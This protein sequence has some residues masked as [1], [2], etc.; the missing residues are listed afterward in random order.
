MKLLMISHT[1]AYKQNIVETNTR[2][3]KTWFPYTFTYDLET[4]TKPTI[5]FFR[6]QTDQIKFL[7]LE[8]EN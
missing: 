2:K 1:Y 7:A 6:E 3:I 8:S 5:Y 4:I